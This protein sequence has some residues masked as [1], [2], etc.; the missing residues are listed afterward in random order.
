MSDINKDDK[1]INLIEVANTWQGEGPDTGRQ[2]MIARFKT[3]NRHCTFCDTWIKMRTSIDGSYSINQLNNALQKTRGLMITGGEP[4]FNSEKNSNFDQTVL[5]LKYCN[6]QV[7]N[8]ETNGYG[9]L[10]LIWE[11]QKIDCDE[12]NDKKIRIIYSPKI[13]NMIDYN[14]QLNLTKDIIRESFVYI[15]VVVD[16][17][18]WCT[19]Y[20]REISDLDINKGKIYLM[21]LGVT[22][23]EISKNWCQCINLADELN[24]NIS[25]RMHIVND[26]T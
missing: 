14:E 26:F 5:M 12:L 13:F 1:I 9:I 19:K 7:V 16:N 6:Y 2:M 25:T 4:T 23:D 24:L 20:I 18:E 3:C 17:N 11:C 15:K 8:I 10:D 21:P 22:N